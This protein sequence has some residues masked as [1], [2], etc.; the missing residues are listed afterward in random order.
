MDFGAHVDA[1]RREGDAMAVA[2]RAAGIDAPVPS[3]PEWTVTDLL[4]HLGRIHRWVAGLLVIRAEAR[5]DHWSESAPPPPEELLDWFA[6]GVP[7]LADA[8]T[9][10]GPD[11]ELWTW[12]PDKSAAFWARRQANE[13]AVHRYDAQLTAG[14][15]QPIVRELA[16]DGINEFFDLIPFWPWAERVRGNGETL[17]LHCTDGDGEWLAQLNPDGLVV[18]REHAKGDVAARGSASDLVL[19]LYGRVPAEQLDVF[20]DAT[21]LTRWR[22][23]VTW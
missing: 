16:V 1:I 2:A 9:E 14:T 3:C 4:G 12:T 22:E 17:H 18:T 6:E 20:G 11:A 7:M 10:A 19:F 23:L 5:G 13:T 15:T 21:L 8:L